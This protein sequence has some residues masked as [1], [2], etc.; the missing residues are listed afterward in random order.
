MYVAIVN[1]NSIV[2]VTAAKCEPK[3]FL[4]TILN[5]YLYQK[6]CVARGKGE[7]YI[8]MSMRKVELMLEFNSFSSSSFLSRLV[9]RMFSVPFVV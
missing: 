7:C 5:K 6:K 2:P 1:Q 9:L 4:K 8:T 3:Y